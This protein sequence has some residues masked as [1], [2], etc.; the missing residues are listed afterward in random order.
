MIFVRY[1]SDII[2]HVDWYSSFNVYV[3]NVKRE[4]N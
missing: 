1:E 3:R 2:I 4:N